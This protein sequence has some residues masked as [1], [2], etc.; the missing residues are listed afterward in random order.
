MLHSVWLTTGPHM[1]G[2]IMPGCIMP[3]C[4]M[5]LHLAT[6]FPVTPSSRSRQRTAVRMTGPC[7][8]QFGEDEV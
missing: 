5:P 3:G 2:C 4:I 6:S 8:T 7:E 1:P